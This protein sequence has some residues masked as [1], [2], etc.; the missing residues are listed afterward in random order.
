MNNKKKQK[1]SLDQKATYRITVQGK[2][3]NDWS[4]WVEDLSIEFGNDDMGNVI[5]TLTGRFDQASLQ[6]L[7]RRFYSLGIP[8]VSATCVDD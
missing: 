2:L 3:N 7:L 5:T 8:L 4:D 1:I 6:G